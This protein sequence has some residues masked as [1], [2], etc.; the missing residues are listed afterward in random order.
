MNNIS[1]H[2]ITAWLDSHIKGDE[3][4]AGYLD[5]IPVANEG[6]WSVDDA[7]AEKEDHTHWKGFQ[8]RTAKG[9]RYEVLKAGE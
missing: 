1:Q 5:L 8:N 6:V 3:E 9:L 7:G 4:A 2:F